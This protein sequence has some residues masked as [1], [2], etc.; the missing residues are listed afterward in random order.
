M[1]EREYRI[2]EADGSVTVMT[3]KQ[4][5]E[6]GAP[7]SYETIRKRLNEQHKRKADEVFASPAAGRARSRAALNGKRGQFG[8]GFSREDG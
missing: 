4:I 6:R 1:A 3:L 8:K 7:I 2:I 5:S